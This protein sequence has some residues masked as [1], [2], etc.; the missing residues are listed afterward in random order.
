MLFC[1]KNIAQFVTFIFKKF[2]RTYKETCIIVHHWKIKKV[3][4][5]KFYQ[6]TK[7]VKVKTKI[8]NII[9]VMYANTE[10]IG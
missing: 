4:P 10:K 7:H 3:F 2:S 6:K 9:R 5:R 8:Q 1:K